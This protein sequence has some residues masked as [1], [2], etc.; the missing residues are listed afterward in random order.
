MS[1]LSIASEI[2]IE[3]A[4]YLPPEKRMISPSLDRRSAMNAQ[5]S[6]KVADKEDK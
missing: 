4:L 2:E 5:L 1:A 6:L 3:W